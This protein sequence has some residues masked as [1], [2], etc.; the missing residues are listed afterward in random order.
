[1][2]LDWV[3]NGCFGHEAIRRCLATP[4]F[5][6]LCGAAGPD[7]AGDSVLLGL[8]TPERISKHLTDSGVRLDEEQYAVLEAMNHATDPLF[9]RSALAWAGKTALAH[10]A[11]KAFVEAYR[12]SRGSRGSCDSRVT[13]GYRSTRGAVRG[14]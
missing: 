1:M 14:R 6:R 13:R 11:L 4:P 8:L 7:A 9:C 5:L 12:G 10:C 2:V 3:G